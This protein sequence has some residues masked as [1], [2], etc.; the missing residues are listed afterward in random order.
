MQASQIHGVLVTIGEIGL[1]LRGPSGTG[2]SECALELIRRGHSLVA[3]DVVEIVDDAAAGGLVGASPAALAGR[4]E[5]QE[6]GVVEVQ[7]LFGAPAIR[8][9]QR[10]DAV[11]DLLPP[12]REDHRQ[13]PVDPAPPVSLLGHTLPAYVLRATGVTAISNRLEIIAQLLRASVHGA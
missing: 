1:L 13:R 7:R 8:A 12:A 9:R 11:V 3:D 2:K 10:I 6:I 5:V 4:L